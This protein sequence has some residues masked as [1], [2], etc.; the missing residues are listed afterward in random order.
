MRLLRQLPFAASAAWD[1]LEA[2][3]IESFIGRVTISVVLVAVAVVIQLV[4]VPP[5]RVEVILLA[6]VGLV[7]VTARWAGFWASVVTAFMAAALI[8]IVLLRLG[9]DLI[10]GSIED[11]GTLLLFLLVAL[12][13]ARA[14]RA[15][16]PQAPAGERAA[17]RPLG[18]PTD[19]I[20]PLTDRE[21]VVLGL[22][23]RGKSNAEIADD[24]GVSRN[25][26][27]THLSHAY[28]KLAVTSRTQAIVRAHELPLSWRRDSPDRVT[29]IASADDDRAGSR[30]DDPSIRGKP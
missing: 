25:T 27:K 14:P 21:T 26:V 29:D 2:A 15:P 24:L 20:E 12:L 1:R 23:A 11:V 7:I 3:R 16:T 18:W 30:V 22:L 5:E 28:G 8:D 9:G 17:I 4:L 10:V 19:A 6:A 13:G